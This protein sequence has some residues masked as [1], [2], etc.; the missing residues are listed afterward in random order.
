MVGVIG[1]RGGD[2]C[3]GGG[4]GRLGDRSPRLLLTVT[5]FS[6]THAVVIFRVKAN[7]QYRGIVWTSIRL[8][9]K[10]LFGSSC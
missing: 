10:L 5:D 1:D 9:F 3:N 4:N 6:T 8:T 2:R 7:L